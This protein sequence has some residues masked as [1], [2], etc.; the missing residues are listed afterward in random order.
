M[1]DLV[2]RFY[3]SFYAIIRQK[4]QK[5]KFVDN[6]VIMNNLAIRHNGPGSCNQ[7]TFKEV[8][9]MQS[10]SRVNSVFWELKPETSEF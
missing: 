2:Y 5:I 6:S 7:L 3:K 8:D 1:V 10:R 4:K 9:I